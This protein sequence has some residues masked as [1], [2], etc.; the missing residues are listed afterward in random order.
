[1]DYLE[2]LQ[3]I[4]TV[5]AALI[6]GICSIIV[7]LIRYKYGPQ[8]DRPPST[9]GQFRKSK[10]NFLTIFVFI[11]V[12]GLFG[13]LISSN[14]TSIAGKV[15][16]S[17]FSIPEI[18]LSDEST[19][20][21]PIDFGYRVME[22]SFDQRGD[23]ICND[24]GA[25]KLGYENN[26]YYIQPGPN[27]GRVAICHINDH[28]LPQGALQISAFP[29]FDSDYYGYGVLF[30]WKGGGFSTTDACV[31]G[32][33]KSKSQTEA[34]F[35]D[36]VAGDYKSATQKIKGYRLDP[37]AHT[38][39]VVL[40]PNGLAQGYIDEMFFAEHQFT[41]CSTGPVGMVAWSSGQKIYFDDLTLFDIP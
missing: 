34:V 31:M 11:L 28:L 22:I 3:P 12:G 5:V 7:A 38:I 18:V 15:P 8:K 26:Q 1:M 35:I 36:W 24:Y 40:Q 41:N 4:A 32:I 2:Y 27:G 37:Q 19:I 39:R 29:E 21:T 25:D 9:K 10:I 6:T 30:G 13:Y 17:Q 16:E 33:R 14:I 23:G 20:P